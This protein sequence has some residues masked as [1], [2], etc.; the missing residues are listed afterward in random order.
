MRFHHSHRRAQDVPQ[1]NC[2]ES[3][4]SLQVKEAQSEGLQ[5]ASLQDM[6]R[7]ALHTDLKYFGHCFQKQVILFRHIIHCLY[8]LERIVPDCLPSYCQDF[9]EEASS[10][11]SVLRRYQP[12]EDSINLH[13][14]GID[15]KEEE[16]RSLRILLSMV[17][18]NT[19][20]L[21][22]PFLGDRRDQQ[23]LHPN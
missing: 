1:C 10:G 3:L 8:D 15:R 11:Q 4:R 23:Q 13:S 17:V 20:L 21:L 19:D 7:V 16:L 5:M 9:K 18:E 6:R 2:W 22:L 14:L 12:G